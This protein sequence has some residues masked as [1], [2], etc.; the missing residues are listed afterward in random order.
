MSDIVIFSVGIVVFAITTTATLLY[1]YVSFL[2]QSRDQ[3][4]G[5]DT[6]IDARP[7]DDDVEVTDGS[8]LL[9]IPVDIA[10]V[11]PSPAASASRYT[12]ASR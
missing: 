1:G 7:D 3:G 9:S 12:Q 5:E 4:I 8:S 10:R 11:S 6:I 2:K